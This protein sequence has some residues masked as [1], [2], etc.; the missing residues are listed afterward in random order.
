[1]TRAWWMTRGAR[2]ELMQVR[3]GPAQEINASHAIAA[4]GRK[5][6]SVTLLALHAAEAA[7]S[8]RCRRVSHIS[9]ERDERLRHFRERCSIGA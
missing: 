4:T 8:G 5:G 3:C 2:A 6:F 1:M 9:A 7:C